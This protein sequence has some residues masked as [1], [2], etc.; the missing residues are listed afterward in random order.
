MI[1]EVCITK[2]VDMYVTV[3]EVRCECGH[4]L[5]FTATVDDRDQ[6]IEI[7][8]QEHFCKQK[9]DPDLDE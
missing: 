8:V 1:E 6:S 2:E 9:N 3:Y 7:K 4:D 5:E